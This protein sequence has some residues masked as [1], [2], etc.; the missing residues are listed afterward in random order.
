MADHTI[1]AVLTLLLILVLIIG[2]LLNKFKYYSLAKGSLFILGTAIS[3]VAG[4][5]CSKHAE[6]FI[7]CVMVGVI[8]LYR[9]KTIRDIAVIVCIISVSCHTIFSTKLPYK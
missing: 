9:N 2:L 8:Y 5:I 6:Y 3:V 1:L 7:I 4:T